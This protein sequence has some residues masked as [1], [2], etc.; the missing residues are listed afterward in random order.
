MTLLFAHLY[1]KADKIVWQRIERNPAAPFFSIGWWIAYSDDSTRR[2]PRRGIEK[3]RVVHSILRRNAIRDR[4]LF[5]N[6][7]TRCKC[8]KPKTHE[9]TRAENPFVSENRT[10]ATWHEP[11]FKGIEKHRGGRLVCHTTCRIVYWSTALRDRCKPSCSLVAVR[12]GF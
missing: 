2:T 5:Q 3:C 11:K 1:D 10:H 9:V 12:T 8:R 4:T 6:V 7:L